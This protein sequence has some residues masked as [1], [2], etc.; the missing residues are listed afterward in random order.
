M[1]NLGITRMRKITLKTMLWFVYFSL[2]ANLRLPP[3]S[4]PPGGQT[5]PTA[6][7]ACSPYIPEPATGHKG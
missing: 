3:E 7:P 6:A 2:P 4:Y 5:L 1:D